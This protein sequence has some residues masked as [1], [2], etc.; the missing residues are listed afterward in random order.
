MKIIK[1]IIYSCLLCIIFINDLHAQNWTQIPYTTMTRPLIGRQSLMQIVQTS[2]I[3]TTLSIYLGGNGLW[4]TSVSGGS[5]GNS[6]TNLTPAILPATVLSSSGVSAF[7]VDQTNPSYI[8]LA[9]DWPDVP[10]VF[11]SST[12]GDFWTEITPSGISAVTSFLMSF[13]DPT[14]IYAGTVDGVYTLTNA[15]TSPVWTKM[16][17]PMD[18]GYFNNIIYKPNPTVSDNIIYTSGSEIYKN[19]NGGGWT[20]MSGTGSGLSMAEIGVLRSGANKRT[21]YVDVSANAIYANVGPDWVNPNNSN[22]VI[23][24]RKLL[25][26]YN[27]STWDSKGDSPVGTVNGGVDLGSG[28]GMCIKI[29]P[30]NDNIVYATGTQLFIFNNSASPKW[31]V[32]TCYYSENQECGPY[33]SHADLRSLGFSPYDP[34]RLYVV[35]DGGF[36]WWTPGTSTWQMGTNNNWPIFFP[37]DLSCSPNGTD[38][39]LVG[40]WDDGTFLYNANASPAW[41]DCFRKGDGG[42]CF[43]YSDQI[44]Y[45]SVNSLNALACQLYKSTDGGAN[46]TYASIDGVNKILSDP[47]DNSI[48]YIGSYELK[49][50][51]NNSATIS[52]I[53]N[54][55]S[56]F[57]TTAGITDFAVA[58]SNTQYMY[59]ILAGRIFKTT[60]GGGTSAGSWTEL[61]WSWG[62]DHPNS[63]CVDPWDPNHVLIAYTR[64]WMPPPARPASKVMESFNGG[65]TWTDYSTGLP[66][67]T[68]VE[69]IAEK[70]S[71]CGLYL[72]TML[73]I[74]YRNKSLSSWQNFSTGLPFKCGGQMDVN[75]KENKIITNSSYGIW[76]SPLYCPGSAALNLTG[77]GWNIF[78]ETTTT[79]TSTQTVPSGV[80]KYRA[81][82]LITL[83]PGF[84]AEAGSDFYA[85]IHNCSSPGNS[86]RQMVSDAAID[87]SPLQDNSQKNDELIV[88]VFPNPTAGDFAIKSPKEI[89]EI[90]ILD[91]SG[92][93][94]FHADH[95]DQLEYQVRFAGNPEGMYIL[96]MTI[97]GKLITK[98]VIISA[99]TEGEGEEFERRNSY[100]PRK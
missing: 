65:S 83:N 44:M 21:F 41:T 12:G 78:K 60:T 73:G 13:N 16:A 32:N 27:G 93:E 7:V 9:T 14:K 20:L 100:K 51:T 68:P 88:S 15:R 52:N 56:A 22:I 82:T 54:F 92:K 6:W 4:K 86:F 45:A 71:N 34:T 70:G 5:V 33:K 67:A 19:V 81:G 97:D 50:A 89:K 79:I 46:F 29:D 58:P 77:I 72:S 64:I 99:E 66:D 37:F 59:V 55:A 85:F 2:S 91:L 40:T 23:G 28:F 39:I 96:N 18:H 11:R 74:F 10:R 69:M 35:H 98:K 17:A 75:Y 38:K 87:Q 57:G 48:F 8:Y 61:T 95:I 80:A 31:N 25:F 47:V 63:I 90:S 42:I 62:W 84:T 3:D 26:K 94:V 24:Y 1:T 30:G 36:S 49:K 43:I 76:T 53:S